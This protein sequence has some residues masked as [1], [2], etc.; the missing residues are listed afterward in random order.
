MQF[1]HWEGI[2]KIV[3]AYIVSLPVG[4]ERERHE[5][6]AGL[7]TFPLVAVAACAF[8]LIGLRAFPGDIAAPSRMLQG[9][10]G[11]IGFLGAGTIMKVQKHVHGTATAA[12]LL[13]TA[14]IG[15]AIAMGL[16]DIAI[17]LSVISLVTLRAFTAWKLIR[18]DLP[19]SNPESR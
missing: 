14:I 10:I 11:G 8:V 12:S 4:W 17:L 5:R 2:L 13:T 19:P 3:V 16:Y 18:E 6:S 9:L 7:R 1:I 15:M